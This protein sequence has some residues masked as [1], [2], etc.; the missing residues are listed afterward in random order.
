MLYRLARTQDYCLVSPSIQ[1]R[2]SQP[3]TECIPLVMEPM[4][5]FYDCPICVL[6]FRSL[7][8][9]VVIGYNLCYSTCLGKV[10]LASEMRA[11][12]LK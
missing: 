12:E 5:G 9:S 3:A 6:D 1:Q 2:Q 11:T 7:Y 10:R 8:P 4:S